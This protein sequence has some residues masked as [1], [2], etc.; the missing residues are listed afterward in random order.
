MVLAAGVGRRLGGLPKCLI[1]LGGK[2]FLQRLLEQLQDL[3]VD[4]VRLLLGHHAA[5]ISAH[6]NTL[7]RALWPLGVQ[8]PQPTD[9]PADSLRFG[10]QSLARLPDRV[11]V[12]LG[13]QPLIT[14]ADM[15]AVLDAYETR[16]PQQAAL[17]PMVQG[18]PGHPVVLSAQACASLR[19]RPSGGLRAWRGE[20]PQ[21]FALWPSDNPHYVRDIDRPEDLDQLARETG[22]AV[23][24]PLSTS[25]QGSDAVQLS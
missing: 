17:V 19:D 24:S 8:V 4:E 11:L 18:Q 12:L 10:L 5:T 22:L 25:G 20:A 21:A 3:E 7:P 16:A 2:S 15:Q 1:E 14:A 13:D 23:R 6:V 9:D